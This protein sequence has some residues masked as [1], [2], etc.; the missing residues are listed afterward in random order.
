MQKINSSINFTCPECK[1]TSEFDH[2]GENQLVTCP[3]CGIEFM[4]VRKG[5]ALL[6]EP[7]EFN[8]KKP[9]T[10]NETARLVELELR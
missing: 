1:E 3:I 8:P 4:T 5:Q 2:V 6:L 7:F 10:Q 9:D